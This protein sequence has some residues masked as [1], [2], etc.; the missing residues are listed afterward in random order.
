[1]HKLFLLLDLYLSRG[2]IPVKIIF[3]FGA[4][5]SS[6]LPILRI[7]LAISMGSLESKLFVS[8]LITINLTDWGINR[9]LALHRTCFW[10]LEIFFPNFL[11]SSKPNNNGITN[12]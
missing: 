10:K 2:S 6:D 3:D 1:M 12:K 11:V 9:F 7:P 8:Q 4:F 5:S